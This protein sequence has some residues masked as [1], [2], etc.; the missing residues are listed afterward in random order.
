[1]PAR[2]LSR[3]ADD[4]GVDLQRRARILVAYLLLNLREV[5]AGHEHEAM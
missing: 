4:L 2:R 1:M 5:E 3:S